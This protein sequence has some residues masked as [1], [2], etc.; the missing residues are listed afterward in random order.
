[1]INLIRILENSHRNSKINMK[2]IYNISISK[3]I[4]KNKLQIQKLQIKK[5]LKWKKL[6]DEYEIQK[7]LVKKPRLQKIKKSNLKFE[8]YTSKNPIMKKKIKKN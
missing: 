8:N 2:C 7:L 5:P 3:I 1:M 6:K 4:R